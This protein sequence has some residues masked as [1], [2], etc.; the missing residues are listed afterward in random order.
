MT[1]YANLDR[2]FAGVEYF[3]GKISQVVVLSDGFDLLFRS[4]NPQQDCKKLVKVL[5]NK[6]VVTYAPN[7]VVK[8]LSK[9]TKTKLY[10]NTDDHS[11]F[12]F[13]L[14]AI[15]QAAILS[16]DCVS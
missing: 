9:I 8:D 16:V 1:C 14:P 13:D 12:R 6:W 15:N 4:S 11:Q 10:W 2:V 7:K 3:D 5:S